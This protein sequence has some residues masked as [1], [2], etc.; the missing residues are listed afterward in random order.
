M[1]M[2]SGHAAQYSSEDENVGNDKGRNEDNDD[3]N[4]NNK[5]R[6]NYQNDVDDDYGDI[7]GSSLESSSL[8]THYSDQD[9]LDSSVSNDDDV[10]IDDDISNDENEKNS[11]HNVMQQNSVSTSR[12]RGPSVNDCFPHLPKGS[13]PHP[14]LGWEIDKVAMEQY[15]QNW[16]K[17]EG[18]AVSKDTRPTVIYWRCVHAGK[19][20]N[21][22][23]L[24]AEVSEKSKR[25]EMLDAGTNSLLS[26]LI[27]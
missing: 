5:G 6:Y 27:K 11:N 12:K 26:G 20:R 14:I 18:F 3:G 22:R 15:M 13:L 9:I 10:S 23:G 25:Q 2:L 8:A 17:Q 16:P 7:Y 21:R 19:Y 24:P 1:L 4:D